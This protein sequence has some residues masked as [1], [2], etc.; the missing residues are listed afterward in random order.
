MPQAI[1]RSCARSVGEPPFATEVHTVSS[2][3]TNCLPTT[4]RATTPTSSRNPHS[5]SKKAGEIVGYLLGSADSQRYARLM[6]RRIVPKVLAL[7]TGRL[8]RGR[9]RQPSTRRMLMWFVV[10]GWREIPRIP[11]DRFPAHFH[12]NLL[13]SGYRKSY[14]TKLALAFFDLMEARG[15]RAFHG[16]M[17]EPLSGGFLSRSILGTAKR[18]GVRPEFYSE[19]PSSFRRIV[20]GIDEPTVIRAWGTSV[21]RGRAW[22]T[23]LGQRYR[24]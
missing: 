6:S 20:L 8:L 5:S 1:V 2:R 10:H 24:L 17:E 7:A 16:Q 13:P 22:L 21:A 4:G 9:Y 15:V 18:L 23:D 12:C 14:Y 11:F 19:S 3:T